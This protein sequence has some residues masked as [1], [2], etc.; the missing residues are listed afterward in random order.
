MRVVTH[1]FPILPTTAMRIRPNNLHQSDEAASARPRTA[2]CQRVV[3]LVGCSSQTW[4]SYQVERN[5]GRRI[6]ANVAKLPEPHQQLLTPQLIRQS[7]STLTGPLTARMAWLRPLPPRLCRTNQNRA[8]W[9]KFCASSPIR[10]CRRRGVEA[11]AL[12]YQKCPCCL[13]RDR[14][15]YPRPTSS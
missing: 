10:R 6:A 15:G 7:P 9:W 1:H 11:Q 2:N 4:P 14:L 3:V 5:D 8:A 12:H 13:Q